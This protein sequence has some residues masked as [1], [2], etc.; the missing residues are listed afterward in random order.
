MKTS[1]QFVSV[2][3]RRVIIPVALAI[4]FVL[5]PAAGFFAAGSVAAA[6]PTASAHG[7]GGHAGGG[8]AG[9]GDAGGG[10]VGGHGIGPARPGAGGY[11]GPVYREHEGWWVKHGL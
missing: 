5:A 2:L 11:G 1:K 4:A 3:A 6:I 8:D 9:G 7:G 10:H